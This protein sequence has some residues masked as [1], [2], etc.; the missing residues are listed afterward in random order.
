MSYN[1]RNNNRSNNRNSN[2]PRHSSASY[3]WRVSWSNYQYS[4]W[5]YKAFTN[6]QQAM[7]Y[8]TNLKNS[9]RLVKLEKWSG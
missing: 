4:S 8:A 1:N 2:A 9:Y 7:I 6:K 5:N 3:I